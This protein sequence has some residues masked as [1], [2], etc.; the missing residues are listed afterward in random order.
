MC[1]LICQ[2]FIWRHRKHPIHKVAEGMYIHPNGERHTYGM[3][4]ILCL[5]DALTFGIYRLLA[6]NEDKL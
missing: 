1:L 4:T 2:L 5:S 3:H 6:E